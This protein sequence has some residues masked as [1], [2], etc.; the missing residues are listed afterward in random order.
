[1]SDQFVKWYSDKALS[2]IRWRL[3]PMAARG[4]FHE[5]YDLASTTEIRGALVTHGEA[6]NDMQLALAVN[7]PLDD[8]GT[9]LAQLLDAQLMART[10][11]GT[12]Y[13]PAWNRHQRNGPYRSR[14]AKAEQ[15]WRSVG[16][17][18][19]L[20]E[21]RV[22]ESRVE[23]TRDS[24]CTDAAAPRAVLI[25]FDY[26]D[27]TFKGI[28]DAD[29]Q[30]WAEAYPAVDV[31]GEIKRAAQWATANTAKRKSNW[32]RFLV[33]WF[34][35]TQ[36]RGGSGGKESQNGR[37]AD[38]RTSPRKHEPPYRGDSKNLVIKP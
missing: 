3:Q 11:D 24:A 18:Y 33:N 12:L 36:E 35:R 22:E 10:S 29:L 9:Q 8:F 38:H 1:M 37:A 32:R 5:L 27:G 25:A 23:E 16:G 30:A 17:F 19:S 28:S 34:S 7:M 26:A 13:F 31:P 20:E 14:G 21:S 4:L 6:M 15:F 2:S